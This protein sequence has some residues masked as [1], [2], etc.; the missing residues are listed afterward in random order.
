[1]KT[2]SFST[3]IPANREL[4]VKLPSDVPTGFATIVVTVSPSGPSIPAALNDL[5]NPEFFGM[6]RDRT[7]I[8]DNLEFARKLRSESWKRPV[9]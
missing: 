4:R 2:V 1:M 9:L 8:G 5:L 7:D 3:D 6:W